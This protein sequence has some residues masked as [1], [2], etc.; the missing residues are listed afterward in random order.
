MKQ[1]FPCTVKLPH[2]RAQGGAAESQK[3]RQSRDL[4][5]NRDSYTPQL[6][7]SSRTV[8]PIR[9]Q[10]GVTESEEAYEPSQRTQPSQHS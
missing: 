2:S 10:A 8:G 5:E 3:T 4:A 1:E 9:R 7:K 6:V